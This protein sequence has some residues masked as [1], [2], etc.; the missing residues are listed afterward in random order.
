M[1]SESNGSSASANLDEEFRRLL[2]AEIPRLRR[3]AARVAPFGVDPDDL[4]HDALE[5]AWRNRAGF[6]GESALSTWLYRIVNNRAADLSTKHSAVPVDVSSLVGGRVMGLEVE[7]PARLIDS[8]SD[9]PHLRAA[10]FQLAPVDRLVVVLHD[11]EGMTVAVIAEACGLS[12]AALHKRLQR[13]RA[14]LVRAVLDPANL[15]TA[16]HSPFCF[17]CR[18]FAADYL[19]DQLDPEQRLAIEAHLR[20]C[21]SCPPLAQ[22]AIGLREVLD[23]SESAFVKDEITSALRA[24]SDS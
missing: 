3:V 20:V 19:N 24:E 17:R 5:R 21:A 6:R 15:P 10:L 22:A 9:N 13:A 18:E 1:D 23:R 7:D 2:E 4:A 8:V 11:G 12:E 14:R 16:S